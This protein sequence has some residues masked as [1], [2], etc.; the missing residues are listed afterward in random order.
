MKKARKM[1]LVKKSKPLNFPIKERKNVD[2]FSVK[3]G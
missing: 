2:N 3:N 1:K